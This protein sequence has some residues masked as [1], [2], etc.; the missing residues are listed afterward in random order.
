MHSSDV[1]TSSGLLD[2]DE[3]LDLSQIR[4]A[5]HQNLVKGYNKWGFSV[6]V[7]KSTEF[8]GFS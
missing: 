8:C 1:L 5:G 6:P 3:G 2:D 7:H 4:A